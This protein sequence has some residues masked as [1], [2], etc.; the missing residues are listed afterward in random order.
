MIMLSLW[1][2]L[3]GLARVGSPRNCLKITISRFI[4]SLYTDHEDSGAEDTVI[5][6]LKLSFSERCHSGILLLYSLD[7]DPIDCNKLMTRHLEAFAKA[8]PNGFT[9]PS[10]VYVVPTCK[11]DST[12]PSEGPRRLLLQL[13]TIVQTLNGNRSR[14]WHASMLPGVFQGQP[15]IAWNAALL[16]LKD[17]TETQANEFFTFP[18][19]ALRHMPARLPDSRLALKDL[20]DL[21]LR[22]FRKKKSGDLDALIT[23]ART[24]LEFTPPE[25]PHYHLALINLANVVCERFKKEDTKADLDKVIALSRAAWGCMLPGDPERQTILLEL[26]DCLY[27][28]FRRG[29]VMADLEEIISLRRVALEHT[30]PSNRCRQ[31]LN[32][33]NSLVEKYD[34]LGLVTD[35]KEAVDLGRAALELCP[36]DHPDHAL[37]Q[38]CLANYLDVKIRKRGARARIMGV[39]NNPSGPSSSDIK[40]FI[41]KTVFEVLETIPLRLL[42]T[43]T[44][45]LCTR[46]L[47]L[48]HFERSPQYRQLL[49]LMS[50][51]NSQPS[52]A[53]ICEAVTRFF[54]FATLSHRDGGDGQGKLQ[55]FCALALRRGFLWAWSDTC[56]MDK[57]SS[58]E[59]QEAIG[60]MFSWYRS[61]SLTLVHLYDA[62]DTGSL[63]DSAWFERGWTLQELLASHTV[64]FY[65]H[66]WSLYM[67]RDVPNHK[68]DPAMLEEVEKAT[69]IETLMDFYPG[70]DNARSKLHWASRRRTTRPEDI[71]YSLF[72]IFKVHLPIFYGE[73]AE[74]ALGRLIAEIISG[75]G[76]VSV[77]DWVGEASSSNSCFPANLVPY[78]TVPHIQL[79][80]SDRAERNN[81]DFEKTQ[82]FYRKLA[83]LPRAGY[84]NSRLILPSIVHQVT[85]VRPRGSSTIPSRYTYE[86]HASRL[87]PLE[88][89]MSVNLDESAG[90]YILVRPWHPKALPTQPGSDHDAV[91]ELLEQLKQP[92]N[93]LLL[94]KLPHNEYRR[95]ASDCMITACP[96]DLNSILDSEVLVPEIV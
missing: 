38:D 84:V 65:T 13:K 55:Q 89:T 54:R 92:F 9:V 10:H 78:Q 58:A 3:L 46:D 53:Q 71:A 93:A 33:A 41:K 1:S 43:P 82:I 60:S 30:S 21:L 74:H 67:N 79:I 57:D 7:S 61:S 4:P 85:E 94:Q 62:S 23:L 88:A 91:W 90:R 68:T 66:D 14:K 52:T 45:V 48:S 73:S 26:D 18:R 86:I 12:L 83:G 39:E 20:S 19:P 50:T 25:H 34:K 17:V 32:L 56:C 75:S 24:A 95:I 5:N 51:S 22:E 42:H 6:W 72:G 81:L 8:L 96:Q 2:A 64:L 76:D 59:L 70:L 63:V 87:T 80:P 16:L 40:Q 11:P 69:G 47:Q 77:L 37:A 27:E 49:S 35:V 29:D 15:E 36:P 28:R 31:L 44:G